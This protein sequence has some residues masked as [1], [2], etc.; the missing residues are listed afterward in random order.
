[1]LLGLLIIIIK[2]YLIGEEVVT[3][4]DKLSKYFFKENKD[5]YKKIIA[6]LRKIKILNHI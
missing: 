1:M 2:I 4:R 6:D 5:Y 3:T